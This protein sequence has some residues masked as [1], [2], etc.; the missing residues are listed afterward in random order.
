[1]LQIPAMSKKTTPPKPRVTVPLEPR[2]FG[3]LE[4]RKKASRRSMA[5][6]AAAIIETHLY[7][8]P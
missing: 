7:A 4:K 2:A 1:M 6:E 3:L 5:Q 8:K